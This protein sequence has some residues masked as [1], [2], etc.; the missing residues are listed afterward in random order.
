MEHRLVFGRLFLPAHE[1]A[2][3]AIEPGMVI[4]NEPAVYQPGEYGIRIENVILCQKWME[5][6]S[7][8]FNEFETLTFVP[9]DTNPVIRELLCDEEIKWLN[10]YHSMVFEKLSPALEPKEV[11]WLSD[12]CKEIN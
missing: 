12:R 5:T 8:I 10:K 2:P 1:Q 3:V 4:S 7:G 6:E 11:D 9:I